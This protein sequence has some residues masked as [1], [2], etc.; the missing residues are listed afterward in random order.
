M[1]I[2]LTSEILFKDDIIK[3]HRLAMED[4][5]KSMRANVTLK[6]SAIDIHE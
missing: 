3:Y 5:Q 1:Q 4:V 2:K 6:A